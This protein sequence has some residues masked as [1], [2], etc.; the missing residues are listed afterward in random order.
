M[1]IVLCVPGK[2]FSDSWLHSW[3][4]TVAALTR[5]GHTWGYSL[6]YDPVV[7]YA[8]NRVLGGNNTAGKIQKPFQGTVAYDYMIWIDSDMVW[9]SLIHI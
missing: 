3:N 5:A 4:D 8:R 9:L 2:Q 7:Y 1:N 6:S